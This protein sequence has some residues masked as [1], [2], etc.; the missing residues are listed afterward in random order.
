MAVI[1]G[2]HE[3]TPD[4][5]SESLRMYLCETDRH[6]TDKALRGEGLDK[7]D[8]HDFLD[9]LSRVNC[10]SIQK[11][12]EVLHYVLCIAHKEL[13]QE[14]KY[15]LDT[16]ASTAREGLQLLVPC[17]D[18]IRDM[19]DSKKP[20]PCKVIKLLDANPLHNEQRSA[21]SYLKR[22]IKGLYDTMLKKFLRH[23]TGAE[24]ICTQSW[25]GSFWLRCLFTYDL[26]CLVNF[27]LFTVEKGRFAS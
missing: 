1:H 27:W 3:M 17:P 5:M 4:I 19:N 2:E 18:A 23:V 15:A 6:V 10:H 8:K 25:R 21:L 7:G 13:I 20:T 12:V 11:H 24:M 14:P 16:I 26:R 22:F 9:L